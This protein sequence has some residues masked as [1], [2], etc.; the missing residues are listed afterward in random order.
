LAAEIVDLRHG[1]FAFAAHEVAQRPR[2][3]LLIAAQAVAH[4]GEGARQ[5]A[6]EVGVAVVPVGN[7]G[8]GEIAQ[9]ELAGHGSLSENT[10]VCKKAVKPAAELTLGWRQ[11]RQ[12]RDEI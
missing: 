1:T 6:Q 2:T 10:S 9:C 5:T 11:L 7:P 8:M 3:Q 12:P 4:A